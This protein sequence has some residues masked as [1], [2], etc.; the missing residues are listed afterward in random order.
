MI[1]IYW[2]II[3]GQLHYSVRKNGGRLKLKW[4]SSGL[5]AICTQTPRRLVFLIKDRRSTV[6][7]QNV[8]PAVAPV[9]LD[10]F[11]RTHYSMFGHHCTDFKKTHTNN[12]AEEIFS[13]QTCLIF[14]LR[15][16]LANATRNGVL[17]NAAQL[18]RIGRAPRVDISV[19][20]CNQANGKCDL[21]TICLQ[22]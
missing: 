21:Q 20:F 18:L 7:H 9:R 6:T 1:C 13:T 2:Y 17:C 3:C 15:C 11:D 5:R 8:V 12:F 19:L 10:S 22:C 14:T 4:I 16:D